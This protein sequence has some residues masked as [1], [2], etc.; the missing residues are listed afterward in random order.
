M[1]INWNTVKS[2]GKK[3]GIGALVVGALSG[4][5]YGTYK[6]IQAYRGPKSGPSSIGYRVHDNLE[7][8]NKIF[9]YFTR[10]E[11]DERGI[12]SSKI[13]KGRTEIVDRN[14][15]PG[16]VAKLYIPEQDSGESTVLDVITDNSKKVTYVDLDD[17]DTVDYFEGQD[18]SGNRFT[19]PAGA[20]PPTQGDYDSD[21]EVEEI[22]GKATADYNRV[23]K[24][25]LSHNPTLA[26]RL[27]STPAKK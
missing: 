23:R 5:G 13:I 9:G 12:D 7:S 14:V 24:I 15:G 26:D 11:E 19:M 17:D 21:L 2:V 3:V 6:G 22:M 1:P 18:K 4:T 10:K 16:I 20:F 25:M 27:G 8:V